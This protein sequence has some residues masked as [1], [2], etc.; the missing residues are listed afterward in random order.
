MF[1]TRAKAGTA[2]SKGK[3]RYSVGIRGYLQ[4]S[5]AGAAK[6]TN[7][8]KQLSLWFAANGARVIWVTACT[9]ILVLVPILFEVQREGQ[10]LSL[11]R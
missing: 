9:T 6:I 10:C 4:K 5:F 7:Y 3:K 8:G 11:E 2:G 1:F